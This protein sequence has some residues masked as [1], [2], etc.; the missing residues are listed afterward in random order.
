ML[1]YLDLVQAR[2]DTYAMQ[3]SMNFRG[4]CRKHGQ[5]GEQT[6]YGS[7]ARP[8]EADRPFSDSIFEVYTTPCTIITF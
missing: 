8:A 2:K 3:H 1:L 6:S 7:L 5:S 4:V